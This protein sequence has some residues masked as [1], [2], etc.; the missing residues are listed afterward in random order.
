MFSKLHTF[1]LIFQLSHS[2][3]FVATLEAASLFLVIMVIRRVNNLICWGTH[4][5][6][7]RP[8]LAWSSRDIRL[9]PLKPLS[10]SFN[11]V[12]ETA[13]HCHALR[14]KTLLVKIVKKYYSWQAHIPLKLKVK[15][16]DNARSQTHPQDN[17]FA[18]NS[19]KKY[20]K[21]VEKWCFG[22]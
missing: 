13:M 9:W 3:M 18:Q 5:E 17:F 7:G 11:P 8:P 15:Q 16:K 22:V 2:A 19:L 10:V 12:R 20:K 6:K 21:G 14:P 4:F 1:W